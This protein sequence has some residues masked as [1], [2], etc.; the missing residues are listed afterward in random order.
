[1][2]ANDPA[3]DPERALIASGFH[4]SPCSGLRLEYRVRCFPAASVQALFAGSL[5]N[6]ENA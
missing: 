4:A 2:D 6:A 5:R 3:I 1:V